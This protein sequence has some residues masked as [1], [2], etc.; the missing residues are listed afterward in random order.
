MH[1]SLL[2]S[3]PL[4]EHDLLLPGSYSEALGPCVKAELSSTLKSGKSFLYIQAGGK[5]IWGP[6]SNISEYFN[7]CFIAMCM[8]IFPVGNLFALLREINKQAHKYKYRNEGLRLENECSLEINPSSFHR[9]IF[10][11]A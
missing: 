7:H 2:P 8:L 5:F 3:C 4:F 9:L 10:I 1:Y 11:S 6:C